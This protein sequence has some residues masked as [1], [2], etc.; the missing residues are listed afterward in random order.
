MK[1]FFFF[2]KK[3]DI[4]QSNTRKSTPNYA[5][6]QLWIFRTMKPQML[7][8]L[9]Y[10]SNTSEATLIM[11]NWNNWNSDQFWHTQLQ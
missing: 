8:Q 9:L 1:L 7:F 2:L 6:L 10:Q 5:K 4:Y 11:Q 3:E